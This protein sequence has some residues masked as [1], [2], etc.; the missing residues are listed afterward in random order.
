MKKFISGFI[1]GIIGMIIAF[2]G[3]I[4]LFVKTDEGTR[5]FKK[6]IHY[7][8]YG[9][10]YCYHG[11]TPSYRSYNSY[12]SYSASSA[13]CN[14]IKT[15]VSNYRF[16][17]HKEALDKKHEIIAKCN[18]SGGI[19]AS[20]VFDILERDTITK[21]LRKYAD[22]MFGWDILDEDSIGIFRTTMAPDNE[23][24]KYRFEIQLPMRLKVE[25]KI[26]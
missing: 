1:F 7:L 9:T 24:T 16:N 18:A 5:L 22:S 19:S 11:S 10:P 23:Y 21:T 12:N 13:I 25:E 2:I 15:K 6:G 8:L 26:S 17:S 3:L 4:M 14:S 20:E